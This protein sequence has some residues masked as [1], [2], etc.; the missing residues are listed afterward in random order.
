MTE[1]IAVDINEVLGGMS[2][3]VATATRRAVIA[4]AGNAAR[5]RRI[6]ELQAELN[7]YLAAEKADPAE[8]AAEG[9]AEAASKV[10]NEVLD[11]PLVPAGEGR[12][13]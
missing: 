6:A 2:Q 3:E 7:V 9:A 5:D 12:F 10:L 13:A 4:E 1:N 8:E 11:G